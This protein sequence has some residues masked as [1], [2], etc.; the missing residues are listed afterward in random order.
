MNCNNETA[1]IKA[2][3]GSAVTCD[4]RRLLRLKMKSG[5]TSASSFFH[6]PNPWT[7]QDG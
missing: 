5:S 1:Q 6:V 3:E 7:A 4:A 2:P